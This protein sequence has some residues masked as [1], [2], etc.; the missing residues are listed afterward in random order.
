MPSYKNSKTQSKNGGRRRKQTKRKLRRG[1]KSRKVMKG[2]GTWVG[3]MNEN[4]QHNFTALLYK[5]FANKDGYF[6]VDPITSLPTQDAVAQAIHDEIQKM[7]M[8]KE[9]EDEAYKAFE[10]FFP[11]LSK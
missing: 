7:K 8:P 9:K 4:D 6:N 5:Y 2:G 1:R 11:K 10:R 3:S